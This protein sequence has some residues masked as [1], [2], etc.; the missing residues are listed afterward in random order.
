MPGQ[1][2]DQWSTPIYNEY[3]QENVNRNTTF[4]SG[5]K[6]SDVSIEWNSLFSWI[7]AVSWDIKVYGSPLCKW[8]FYWNGTFFLWSISDHISFDTW[9]SELLIPKYHR[10]NSITWSFTTTDWKTITVE[11]WLI[12]NIL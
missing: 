1:V 5:Q 11:N 10:K 8:E 9:T 7:I 12:T 4:W 6:I 3:I 2:S